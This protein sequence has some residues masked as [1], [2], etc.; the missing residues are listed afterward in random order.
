MPF[1]PYGSDVRDYD[2][3]VAKQ[4]LD[5]REQTLIGQQFWDF[6]GGPG[7]YEEVLQIYGEVG[8][9]LKAQIKQRFGL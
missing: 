8:Q 6:V 7:A 3:S 1:N 9:Q 2:H 4:Y 5:I